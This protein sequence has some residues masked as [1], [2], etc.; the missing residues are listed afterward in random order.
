MTIIFLIFNFFT[1]A[2][3]LRPNAFSRP[4]PKPQQ[5]SKPASI[6]PKVTRPNDVNQWGREGE[7]FS[8]EKY[9]YQ[10]Q[11]QPQQPQQPLQQQ[12]QQQQ[13]GTNFQHRGNFGVQVNG[14]GQMPNYAYPPNQYGGGYPQQNGYGQPPPNYPPGLL[15]YILFNL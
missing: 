7:K 1:E 12:P 8:K 2:S 11:Q 6:Q 3:T 10:Q 5:Q 15:F 9:N 13:G 4:A 14:A